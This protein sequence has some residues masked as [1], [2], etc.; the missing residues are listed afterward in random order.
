MTHLLTA[1]ECDAFRAALLARLSGL[2]AG[3]HQLLTAVIDDF[4]AR[5]SA[6][7]RRRAALAPT[8]ASARRKNIGLRYSR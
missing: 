2:T 1:P 8:T 7:F 5:R 6:G 4:D 3:E